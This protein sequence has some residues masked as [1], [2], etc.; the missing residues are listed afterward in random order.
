MA[1][2][3]FCISIVSYILQF[4]LV[5]N[6]SVKFHLTS[7]L[8]AQ[9]YIL[10]DKSLYKVQF[11]SFTKLKIPFRMM[12]T[13]N[14]H[15]SQN[16]LGQL[17][18]QKS[19][20]KPQFTKLPWLHEAGFH[21]VGWACC[22]KTRRNSATFIYGASCLKTALTVSIIKLSINDGIKANQWPFSRK[23]SGPHAWY[24][25]CLLNTWVVFSSSQLRSQVSLI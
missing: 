21:A 12:T 6:K 4:S 22:R 20:F 14:F 19:D 3:L 25:L 13:F 11:Y 18:Y 9:N 5:N 2:G 16:D 10:C 8:C 1:C 23:I 24:Y 17:L 15:E 7:S